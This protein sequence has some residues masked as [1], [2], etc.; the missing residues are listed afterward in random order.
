M[1][2]M[3]HPVDAFDRFAILIGPAF[4]SVVGIKVLSRLDVT[5]PLS[6]C[7]VTMSQPDSRRRVP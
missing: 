1:G 4:Q 3:L 5:V 2:K 6:F 7:T